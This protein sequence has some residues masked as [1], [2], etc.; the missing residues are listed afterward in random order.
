MA[1]YV[2][3]NA[4]DNA[5][6]AYARAADGALA[7]L[8]A[9]ATGGAGDGRPHLTSQGSVTLTGDGRHLLVTNAGSGD[10]SLLAVEPGGLGL[11]GVA[12]A[13][14]APR[15]VAEHA[16]LVYVLDTAAPALH[17]FRIG[18]AGLEPLPGAPVAVGADPAQA[19]FSP[20]GAWLVV[21]LRG[22]D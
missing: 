7:P 17:G 6:L 12:P 2:Q 19:G 16:G 21:T 15:S 5:V 3:T 1:V 20:D 22:E 9:F 18:A 10:V 11:R 13:G 4:P 14:D 8:G